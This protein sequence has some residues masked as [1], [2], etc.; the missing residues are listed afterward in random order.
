[1]KDC[2]LVVVDMLYDF[3]DGSMACLH[4]EEAVQASL[5]FIRDKTAEP[6]ETEEVI[7]GAFPILF[8]RDFHP[9]DHC[10]FREQG[11]PWPA[12]CVQGTRGADVHE[13][14]APYMDE[15]LTFYKGY[16]R[17]K[18]QYSGFEGL[19]EAGQSLYDVLDIM[20]IKNVY[21]CGIVTEY[22]VRNTCEDLLKAGFN[23]Y[24]L[25]DALGYVDR[26]GHLETLPQL[27]AEGVRLV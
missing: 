22:C 26:T 17:E 27:E 20:D 3:I 23:V 1:M 21:V 13:T 19:N 7:R 24:V 16:D 5:D 14:L 10:S 18:E 12:H 6:Q 11:G 25:Q 9:A 4:A 8:V 15:A 2:A